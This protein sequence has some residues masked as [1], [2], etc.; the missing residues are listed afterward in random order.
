MLVLVAAGML[1]AC[2]RENRAMTYT[3]YR[4]SPVDPS[5]RIH[6][7]TFDA[8]DKGSYNMNNCQMAARL[9]NA[10]VTASAK[11]EGKER[12]RALGFWCEDGPYRDKGI[13]PSAF[14]EEFPTDV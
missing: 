13:I 4:N 14:A 10:N 8:A 9:L 6:W 7:A 3:L 12:D 1:T 11:A 5:M 2:T